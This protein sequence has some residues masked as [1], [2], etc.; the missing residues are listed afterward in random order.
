MNKWSKSGNWLGNNTPVELLINDVLE[1]R[2]Q[3]WRRCIAD[4]AG[5]EITEVL[6]V[7]P[8]DPIA[9]E[10]FIARHRHTMPDADTERVRAAFRAILTG[11]EYR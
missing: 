4:L 3:E 11:A 9:I 5:C 8:I 6:T 10:S 7:S 1:I 2:A